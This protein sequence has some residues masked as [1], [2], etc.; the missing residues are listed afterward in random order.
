MLNASK[1]QLI[2]PI[3]PASHLLMFVVAL[4]L[5]AVVAFVQ[6]QQITKPKARNSF[7]TEQ[8]VAK[9]LTVSKG[10]AQ[11]AVR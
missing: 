5:A 10:Y 4:C 1:P 7:S 2:L 9:T 11:V 3:P 8:P 6:H